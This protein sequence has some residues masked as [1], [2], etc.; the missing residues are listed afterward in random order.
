VATEVTGGVQGEAMK[1]GFRTVSIIVSMLLA[2]VV[3]AVRPG[4]AVPGSTPEATR[5]ES[6][7][8][9]DE[10]ASVNALASPFRLADSR[11]NLGITGQMW[12][13]REATVSVLGIGGVPSSGVG[14]V[15]VNV[16]VVNPSARG[17]M[18]LYASGTAY[19][20]TANVNFD[21][22]EVVSNLV[23][24]QAG[25]NGAVTVRNAVGS[26]HVVIDVV[27]WTA[28]GAG[29]R[30]VAPVRIADSR[31][32]L[33]IGG[34]M[35]AGREAPISVR[36]VGGVPS[37]GVGTVI[38][39]VAV[40]EPSERGWMTLFPGGTGYPGTANVNFDR[41]D[42]VSNLAVARVGADGTI[43][44]RNATGSAHVVIDLVGWTAE[45]S[46][47]LPVGPARIADS[48]TNSTINGIMWN[49]REVT[50]PVAGVAGVPSTGV[51]SVLVNVA[52]VEPSSQG[53]L[54]LYP[55]GAGYPGTANVNFDPGDVVSNLALV[56]VGSN[57]AI[58]VRNAIGSVH[59]IVDVLG[60]VPSS[61]TPPPTGGGSIVGLEELGTWFEAPA[62]TRTFR[63]T[64]QSE[65][66]DGQRINAR[67]I[68]AIPPGSAPGG[69]RRVVVTQPGT[70]G[71]CETCGVSNY[72][73]VMYSGDILRKGAVL[74]SA[75][76]TGT[77]DGNPD[78]QSPYLNARSEGI[79]ILD[80]VRAARNISGSQAT[81]PVSMIGYSLGGH[82]VMSAAEL[83]GGAAGS[84]ISVSNVAVLDGV[85]DLEESMKEWS[86]GSGLSYS[87]LLAATWPQV[88]P[89]LPSAL[90]AAGRG[91]PLQ[92]IKWTAFPGSISQGGLIDRNVLVGDSRWVNRLRANS[93]GVSRSAGSVLYVAS[94]PSDTIIPAAS[95][96]VMFNRMWAAGSSLRT[97][98]AWGARHLGDANGI[99]NRCKNVAIAWAFAEG[100]STDC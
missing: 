9:E 90:T 36:G 50:V 43:I 61:T 53:W 20:G 15:L 91:S 33:G 46:G 5:L 26:A 6:A 95:R 88:Y 76:Y 93:P 13:G 62:G 42:V 35:W 59:V 51:E 27:G 97:T 23:V 54:T 84:G 57:G 87:Y 65:H 25:S 39:N 28:A 68:V 4:Q 21:S 1:Q 16:A 77:N 92:E 100:G 64:Y 55:S 3:T 37:S 52:V 74:V 85:A 99:A 48:R 56:R 75:D 66:P 30:P 19:P 67:G 82:A 47:L 7:I 11:T 49:G 40:V 34:A 69:A 14:S 41:G 24:V 78:R 81:G 38:V 44:V 58:T 60:W 73:P 22:G 86:S 83:A 98:T 8:P 31:S 94:D 72:G 32:N 2:T 18:T 10:V 70:L 80:L 12:A 89:E 29:I 96:S 17:W 79:A 71:A 63:V 45:S